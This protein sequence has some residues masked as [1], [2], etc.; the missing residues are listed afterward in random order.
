MSIYGKQ[1]ARNYA[2]ELRRRY[3]LPPPTPFS[4]VEQ[5]SLLTNSHLASIDA[6]GDNQPYNTSFDTGLLTWLSSILRT[7]LKGRRYTTRGRA[8]HIYEIRVQGQLDQHWSAW[9]DGLAISY[10][11]EEARSCMDH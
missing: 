7:E 6:L 3:L 1:G 11:A 4:F 10:V 2:Q 9:F 5:G 8:M